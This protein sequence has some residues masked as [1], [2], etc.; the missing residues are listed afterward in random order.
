M[1]SPKET[2]SLINNSKGIAILAHPFLYNMQKNKLDEMILYLKT[3]G[4]K[5]IEC[6]YSTHTDEETE[7]LM[8]IAKKY[9]LKISGGSDFHG[10]N[11]PKLDLGIGYGKLYVPYSILENLRK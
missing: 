8:S 1:I 4:L 5:G 9:N 3:V 11:K 2:I 6:I 7:Y 10:N